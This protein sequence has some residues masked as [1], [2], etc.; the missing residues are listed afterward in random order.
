MYAA[1]FSGSMQPQSFRSI[2]ASRTAK[3]KLFSCECETEI[4]DDDDDDD[5]DDDGDDD[6]NGGGDDDDDKG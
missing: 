6:D 5:D 2:L 1:E 4:E 3:W